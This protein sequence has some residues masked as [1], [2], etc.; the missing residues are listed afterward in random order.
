MKRLYL[1]I[2]FVIAVGSISH[3]QID[4]AEY[5]IDD[6][7][8]YGSGTTITTAGGTTID[9]T[10]NIA[11]GGISL[12]FHTLF[13]R[14][15]NISGFWGLSEARLI[16]VDPTGAG[17]VVNI[18][19][20]E[21]FFDADPGYGSGT[22]ITVS[23]PGATIDEIGNIATGALSLGFHT[24]FIRVQNASGVWGQAEARLVYVDETGVGVTVDVSSIE[25]FFD[26]DPGYG[27]GTALT[28]ITPANLVDI[29]QNIPTGA[30]SIGFH[31][32]FIR[33]Q[34]A[35]GIWGEERR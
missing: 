24:L 10:F 30:L 18:T 9:E 28:V 26:A 33:A 23:T 35:N 15:R 34:D 7:P 19:A 32:L 12:G 27:A 21:Y 3:G 22:A 2:L 31:T 14:V 20:I 8:G 17:T 11:T 13:I 5:Y 6:D 4:A 16:Y 29:T 25:Y 1:L